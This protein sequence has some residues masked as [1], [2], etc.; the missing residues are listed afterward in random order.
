MTFLMPYFAR[1]DEFTPAKLKA[2]NTFV[3]DRGAYKLKVVIA[4]LW[5]VLKNERGK[6][7][8]TDFYYV[9]Y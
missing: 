1:E 2:K 3:L 8:K 6:K 9:L 5:R 4:S 7:K